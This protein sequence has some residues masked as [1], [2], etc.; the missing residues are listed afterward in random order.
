MDYECD[1]IVPFAK[2]GETTLD[3]LQALCPDCHL[4][5]TSARDKLELSP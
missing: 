1:H 3:N 4:R 2:G 5:K